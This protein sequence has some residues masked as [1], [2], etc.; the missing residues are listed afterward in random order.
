MVWIIQDLKPGLPAE[1]SFLREIFRLAAHLQQIRQTRPIDLA[2][3]FYT[4]ID[5]CLHEFHSSCCMKFGM[6]LQQRLDG[7]TVASHIKANG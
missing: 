3:M 2:D 4:D 7:C 1:L 6:R 5:G